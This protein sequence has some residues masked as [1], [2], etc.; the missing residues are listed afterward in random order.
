MSFTNSSHTAFTGENTFNHVQGNQVNINL[1][2]SQ[3]VVKR[4]KYDQFR[5]VIHGDMIVLKEIH[6]KEISD[7]EWEWKYGKVTG[8]H[9]ARRT[10]CTVQ[11]YPDRQSK[12]TVVMY[13]G[14]DAECI[15]EKEFEK[16]SRSRNPLAA[17][18]F[19]INRS[20]IPMLIFHDELIPCAHFFNK[21]SV[22]MDVYIVHLRTNMRCSQHN[23]WMNT[24]SG[25]LFMGPDGPS[26][27]GLWSDAVESIVVPNTV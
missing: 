1:N 26:A 19:G 10:T 4:A 5:Q 15:W 24:T 9:K 22:W 16:F 2:A 20:D 13:E 14:E 8:K 6:S 3:A 7:W 11:V 21:E 27:P 12:F 23:L 25:V 18:L 17:Q